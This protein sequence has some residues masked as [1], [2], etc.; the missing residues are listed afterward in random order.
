MILQKV[1]RRQLPNKK[2]KSFLAVVA[3]IE[4]MEETMVASSSQ[5]L[6]S[7]TVTPSIPTQQASYSDEFFNQLYD[8]F[9]KSVSNNNIEII[10][11]NKF[12]RLY[13]YSLLK[14]IHDIFTKIFSIPE[15]LQISYSL[16][17]SP[18]G[19]GK[20]TL[21]GYQLAGPLRAFKY[22]H[23]RYH[24]L[25]YFKSDENLPKII[26]T[27]KSSNIGYEVYGNYI[28]TSSETMDLENDLC[29]F[30]AIR[31]AI[32]RLSPKRIIIPI[33]LSNIEYSNHFKLIDFFHSCLKDPSKF[34]QS[35]LF[36][37]KNKYP[38]GTIEEIAVSFREEANDYHQRFLSL[39]LDAFGENKKGGMDPSC[40]TDVLEGQKELSTVA[41]EWLSDF[42]SV[43][44]DVTTPT[45]GEKACLKVIET[46]ENY[47]LHKQLLD[48]YYI[49]KFYMII[50]QAKFVLGDFTKEDS[51]KQIVEWESTHESLSTDDFL[52]YGPSTI[53]HQQYKTLLLCFSRF[54]MNSDRTQ[55]EIE[56]YSSYCALLVKIIRELNLENTENEE[57]NM[58]FKTFCERFSG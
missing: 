4:K 19:Y 52:L 42:N 39:C 33:D 51:R 11:G 30:M 16:V 53:Q 40:S 37:I 36:V 2:I 56:K 44:K 18:T 9:W 21:I 20:S 50:M 3:T 17:L 5:A 32:N 31:I 41:I 12:N 15:S 28:D 55:P 27:L 13:Q 57:E 34:F 35:T 7:S 47:I 29:S 8:L 46:I 26:H 54:F 6:G 45:E 25:D 58:I 49:M 1:M 22:K 10:M 23:D 48:L 43:A 38:K 14:N 24:R